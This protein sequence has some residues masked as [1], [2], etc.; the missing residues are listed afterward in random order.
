MMKWNAAYTRRAG[1]G[2]SIDAYESHAGS[3]QKVWGGVCESAAQFS[4]GVSLP[5]TGYLPEENLFSRNVG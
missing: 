4:R 2:D 5:Y 1:C 3:V